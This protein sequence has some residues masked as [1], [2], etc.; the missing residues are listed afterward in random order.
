MYP[1]QFHFFLIGER[2]QDAGQRTRNERFSFTGR[3]G[4]QHVMATRRAN[5][6]GPFCF[7]LPPDHAEV[8][9]SRVLRLFHIVR[10]ISLRF[11]NLHP[12]E[13]LTHKAGAMRNRRRTVQT[14][15]ALKEFDN[16]L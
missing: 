14:T 9:D 10:R 11:R 12:I 8:D 2:R 15:L 5:Q 16:L 4:H 6:C 7:V 13:Y 1:S 3:S